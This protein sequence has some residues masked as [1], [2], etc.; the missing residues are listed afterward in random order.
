MN[1]WLGL[2]DKAYASIE[3][4]KATDSELYEIL[5]KHITVETLF[6]RFVICEN[7]GGYYSN[8]EITRMR[9]EFYDDCAD[10]KIE[11]YGENIA[12]SDWFVKWGVA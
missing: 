3:K 1:E 11:A 8:D 5:R 2:C 9:Q 7:Y 4:Y 10:I 12:L 6:P